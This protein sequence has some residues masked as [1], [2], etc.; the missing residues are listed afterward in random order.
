MDFPTWIALGGYAGLGCALLAAGSVSLLAL[1]LRRGTRQQIALASLIALLSCAFTLAPIWWLL[2]R[3]DV[4]GPNLSAQEVAFWL[5]WIS[6]FGWITPLLTTAFFFAF[7]SP[8]PVAAS[9][10]ARVSSAPG[11]TTALDDAARRTYPFGPDHPWGSLTPT[12]TAATAPTIDLSLEV[13]LIGRDLEDDVILDDDLVSRRHA[14]IR[15]RTGQAYLLDRGSLNGTLRN[16]QKARG[17]VPLEDG[18]SVQFGVQR[19]RF[20]LLAPA[21]ADVLEETRKV[22]TSSASH[23]LNSATLALVGEGGA[24]AGRRW[25]LSERTTRIG[26]DPAAGVVIQDTSVSRFHAQITR[27]AGGY[28][29]AD[30]DSSNG[31]LVNGEPVTEPRRIVAGDLLRLG[32][33]AL[34]CEEVAQVIAPKFQPEVTAPTPDGATV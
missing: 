27:Q 2:R 16:A 4:Y 32:E 8:E 19:Y 18:D 29:L 22:A 34:R 1:R 26:R 6:L 7:A 3:F 23:P 24:L 20:T 21:S 33:V 31:T 17:L 9:G 15:W 13:T 10:K 5:I 11:A 25:E 14:E 30:L 12:D 28:Y